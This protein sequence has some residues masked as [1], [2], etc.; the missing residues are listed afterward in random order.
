MKCSGPECTRLVWA[1]DLCRSHYQQQHIRGQQLSIL[2]IQDASKISDGPTEQ[3]Y[4]GQQCARHTENGACL[5][6]MADGKCVA[7][8]QENN[9][10]W[11]ARNQEKSKALQAA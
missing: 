7:S 8:V 10:L 1:K 11:K 6:Y 9:K 2:R 3:T 4:V 5:R